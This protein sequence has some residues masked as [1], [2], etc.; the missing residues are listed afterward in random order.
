MDDDFIAH[1]LLKSLKASI[2]I[3]WAPRD[4]A[5]AR[6]RVLVNRILRR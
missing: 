6:L 1:E 2:T 3:D 4:S 5:R